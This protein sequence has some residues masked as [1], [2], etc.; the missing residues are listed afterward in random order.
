MAEFCNYY[1]PIQL[2]MD[3]VKKEIISKTNNFIHLKNLREILN[4]LF[5]LFDYQITL[6]NQIILF[7]QTTQQNNSTY[8]NNSDTI[9]K[10][11]NNAQSYDNYN[12]NCYNKTKT[13]KNILNHLI[14]INKDIMVSKIIKFLSKIN[15]IFKVK[16]D[17]SKKK[18]SNNN[19]LRKIINCSSYSNKNFLVC[20]TSNIN[21][22]SFFNYNKNINNSNKKNKVQNKNNIDYSID[23]SYSKYNRTTST[24][25]FSNNYIEKNLYKPSIGNKGS[26]FLNNK[27]KNTD[28]AERDIKKNKENKYKGV[29]ND[30]KLEEENVKKKQLVKSNSGTN[31]AKKN[32]FI[33]FS[34]ENLK[35]LF[36]MPMFYNGF[37]RNKINKEE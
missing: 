8:N 30:L 27:D 5:D 33:D 4:L 1:Q 15:S 28:N 12:Y 23:S 21:D 19:S 25:N 2:F 3:N 31:S 11:P 35:S 16:N 32:I 26:N 6:L 18:L 17:K 13:Q 29:I 36:S 37:K 7:T 34:N 9:Y 24:K 20:N 22:N 14:N 10:N